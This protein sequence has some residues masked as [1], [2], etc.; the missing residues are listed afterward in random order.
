MVNDSGDGAP[1]T[2]TFSGA[3]LSG[4]DMAGS[5]TFADAD[6]IDIQLGASDDTFYVPDT[7]LGITAT[8]NTDGGNDHVYVGTVEGNENGGTLDNMLGTFTVEGGQS[9]RDRLYLNDQDD[10]SGQSFVRDERRSRGPV[11]ISRP[12]RACGNNIVE[13]SLIETAVLNAGHGTD[14]IDLQ[15]T[16]REQASRGSVSTFTVNTGGG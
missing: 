1:N 11:T 13:Y 4:L 15:G 16:H 8:L 5:I 12:F 2:G 10:S 7:T 6:N 3:T 9:F 14:S